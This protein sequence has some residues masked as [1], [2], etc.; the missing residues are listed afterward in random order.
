VGAVVFFGVSLYTNG[1]HDVAGQAAWCVLFGAG[2]MALTWLLMALTTRRKRP[3][4]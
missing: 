1:L 4:Q 3:R 2:A